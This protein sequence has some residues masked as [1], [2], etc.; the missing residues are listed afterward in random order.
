MDALLLK[1]IK[2]TV[3]EAP[4]PYSGFE[5]ATV[6]YPDGLITLRVYENQI[7]NFSEDQRANILLEKIQMAIRAKGLRCEMEGV[8]GDAPNRSR[9]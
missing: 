5:V 2:R 1:D 9:G 7:M 8:A 6:V 4:K 3:K